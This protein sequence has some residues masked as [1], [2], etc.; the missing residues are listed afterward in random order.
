MIGGPG[1]SLLCVYNNNIIIPAVYC[2]SVHPGIQGLILISIMANE[3]SEA[4]AEFR[5]LVVKD[6]LIYARS[7]SDYS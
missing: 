1:I 2:L 5:L 6:E 7:K 4:C 3:T